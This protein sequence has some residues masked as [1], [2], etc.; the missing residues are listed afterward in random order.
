MADYFFRR[1]LASTFRH[2]VPGCTDAA[3][4]FS[5]PPGEERLMRT[6]F[7]LFRAEWK[8]FVGPD[9]LRPLAR[10]VPY[11][12]YA[13]ALTFP[14]LFPLKSGDFDD[15][16]GQSF[17]QYVF[18]RLTNEDRRFRDSDMWL[19]WVL[20]KTQDHEIAIAV[21]CVL[22]VRH[23]IKAKH[24]GNGAVYTLSPDERWETKGL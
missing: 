19:Q 7:Q 9:P 22:T 23:G 18:D 11:E 6:V 8:A 15:Q 14:A 1:G 3:E 5:A 20:S 16:S 2:H 12:K 4:D 10:A 13:E 21:N 17:E 24:I